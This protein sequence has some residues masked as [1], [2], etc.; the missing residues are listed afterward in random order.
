MRSDLTAGSLGSGKGVALLV[1]AVRVGVQGFDN[2]HAHQEGQ[3][4]WF[5]GDLG[6]CRFGRVPVK[7]VCP[8]GTGGH[9][10]EDLVQHDP[11]PAGGVRDDDETCGGIEAAHEGNVGDIVLNLVFLVQPDLWNGPHPGDLGR[12]VGSEDN[13]PL[14]IH[15]PAEVDVGGVGL[16]IVGT[17]LLLALL[18]LLGGSAG[19]DGWLGAGPLGGGSGGLAG[20]AGSRGGWSQDPLSSLVLVSDVGLSDIGGGRG[21]L[22]M[23]GPSSVPV[24]LGKVDA[25]Q[26]EVHL[27]RL[28]LVF[29]GLL[30][31]ALGPLP[32]PPLYVASGH[33]DGHPNGDGDGHRHGLV[34]EPEEG[35]G[36][37]M[38]A[39]LSL[40][41]ELCLQ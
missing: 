30:P 6:N 5:A 39:L 10:G 28:L 31:L 15:L 21:A 38:A 26:G 36:L 23:L 35:P 9:P 7:Q 2:V 16:G 13:P 20:N 25:R 18:C 40:E 19:V 1:C 34:D 14:G 24:L 29:E 27:G 32:E 11:L 33:G 12:A 17:V 22:L 4:G 41:V 3:H 8:V 37:G